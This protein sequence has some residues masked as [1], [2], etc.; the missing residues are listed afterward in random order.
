MAESA[1]IVRLAVILLSVCLML[2]GYQ[3]YRTR[4]TKPQNV[5]ET[6]IAQVEFWKYFGLVFAFASVIAFGC[7]IMLDASEGTYMLFLYVGGAG[8]VLAL[9][10]GVISGWMRGG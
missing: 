6:K 4:R 2:V 9:V 1:G 10:A 7:A 3:R 8:I 5:R